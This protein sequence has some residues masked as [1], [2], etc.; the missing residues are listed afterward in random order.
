MASDTST[1]NGVSS[2][3]LV[4]TV[5]AGCSVLVGVIIGFVYSWRMSLVALGCVPFMAF[6]GGM[7]AKM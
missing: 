6:G 7:S 2:E 3:G 1:I 5:E 4:S